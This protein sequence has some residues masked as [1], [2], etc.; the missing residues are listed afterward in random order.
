M[1]RSMLLK[2]LVVLMFFIFLVNFAA[3]KFYWYYSVWYFDIIMHFL[4]GLWLGLFF[5]YIFSGKSGPSPGSGFFFKVLLST[6]VVGILWE[7]YEYYL[8]AVSLES[9]DLPD[10]LYDIFFDMLGAA[11]SLFYLFKIIVSPLLNKVQSE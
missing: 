7:F 11:A 5:A 2:H 4:G 3:N 6:L 1:N 9:F 10:T 8:N